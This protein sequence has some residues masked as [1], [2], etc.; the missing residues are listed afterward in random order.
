MIILNIIYEQVFI[1]RKIFTNEVDGGVNVIIKKYSSNPQTIVCLHQDLCDIIDLVNSTFTFPLMFMFVHTTFSFMITLF[2]YVKNLMTNPE[3]FYFYSVF[4]GLWMLLDIFYDFV[5]IYS[6]VTAV[7]EVKKTA[8]ITSRI[9]S[10]SCCSHEDKKVFKTFLLQNHY[11]NVNF[12]TPFF[13]I[14]W[15][16][17]LTVNDIQKILNFS[18]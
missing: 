12:E 14:H 6:S 13:I 17:L 5:I 9:V 1:F 3:N 11:R 7:E 2:N 8:V 4:D 18:T 10:T 15:N 16:L